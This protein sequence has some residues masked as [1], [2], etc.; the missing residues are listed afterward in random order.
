METLLVHKDL[1]RTGF[2]ESLVELLHLEK[3]GRNTAA[4]PHVRDEKKIHVDTGTGLSVS[5]AFKANMDEIRED[6]SLKRRHSPPF[7][8]LHI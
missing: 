7:A 6:P 2:F 8:F 3:V 1:I 5:A 4:I